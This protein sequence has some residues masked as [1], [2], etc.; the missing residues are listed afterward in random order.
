M[1]YL[2]IIFFIVCTYSQSVMR[3]V[4]VPIYADSVTQ[5]ITMNKNEFLG[6]VHTPQGL[7]TKLYIESYNDS[8]SAWET[9]TKRDTSYYIPSDSTKNAE[10]IINT[11]EWMSRKKFRFLIEADIADTQYIY[12][13]KRSY[14]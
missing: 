11:D 1:K 5:N 4:P 2:I 6:G 14:K 3:L 10:L 12:I 8:L 13:D 7:T 9:V